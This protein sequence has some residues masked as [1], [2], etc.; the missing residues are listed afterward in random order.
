MTAQPPWGH[1]CLWS[2][3]DD[4]WSQLWNSGSTGGGHAVPEGGLGTG[5]VSGVTGSVDVENGIDGVSLGSPQGAEKGR[6]WVLGRARCTVAGHGVKG[7]NGFLSEDLDVPS[8]PVLFCVAGRNLGMGVCQCWVVGDVHPGSVDVFCPVGRTPA[9]MILSLL[10]CPCS[11]WNLPPAAAQGAWS[12][13]LC[14]SGSEDMDNCCKHALLCHVTCLFVL[15]QLLTRASTDEFRVSGP[16]DPIVAELGG[17]A[18][19]PCSLSPAMSVENMEELRWYRTRFLEAVFVYRNQQEQEEEQMDEYLGRTSLVKDQFHQ[20]KA[21]LRIHKVWLSDSG[22]Y[23]CFFKQGPYYE[24]AIL[25]L[26]VAGM[27]SVPE[28]HI[29]GTEDGGVCVVCSASGWYPKPQ[30]QWRDSRGENL[31]ASSETHTE[32]AEGLFSMESTLVVR[33]RSL[34]SVTCSTFN[35]I[36]GQEKAMV[37][38]IPAFAVSM[39]M[40]GLLVLGSCCF[41]R[42]EQRAR[43]QVHQELENLRREQE[44]LRKTKEHALKTAYWRR[45][46]FQSWSVTLDPDT[47]HPILAISKDRRRVT[48]KDTTLCLDDLFCVL[49]MEGISSGRRYWEVEIRNGG[50]SKWI[51]G[52]CREDVE[53]KGFYS[54]CPQK[55]VWTVGRSSSGYWAYID[56]GRASLSFR[57]AP[58]RVGVFVDYSEGDISFYN[59]SEMSHIF[60]FREAS[61]SGTLFPYFRLKSGDVSM[62]LSSLEHDSEGEEGEEKGRRRKGRKG[63]RG[64]RRKREKKGKRLFLPSLE[65]SG[66][67]PGEGLTPGSRVVYS[68]P[69]EESPF[70]PHPGD[71]LLP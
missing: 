15:A 56:T 9:L 63:R 5:S 49:G 19:L 64:K 67:P 34:G 54:E 16:S 3:L 66:N 14:L 55:G 60:S 12:P 52:V 21:A 43:L 18:I 30:V 23:I 51:L 42:R 1:V 4:A 44:E 59:M 39:T 62:I 24:E 41:L 10:R 69:G 46:H 45:E 47:A 29:K 26:K 22:T 32:D 11:V 25:E 37:M 36:L 61:F 48:R 50:S 31:P 53:R 17:E 8:S 33:D 28:V 65:E 2:R 40:M 6:A 71:T 13:H 68:P 35:P 20:G 7:R 58:Q 27:G 70:L 57:Q 38:F